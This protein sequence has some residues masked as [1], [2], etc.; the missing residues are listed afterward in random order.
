MQ[1]R[2]LLKNARII[3]EGLSYKGGIF[4]CG[5]TIADIFDYSVENDRLREK[6]LQGVEVVDLQGCCLM[7]GVIDTHVHFR[8][9][10]ATHKGCIASESEAARLGGV[11]SYLDMPNNNPPAIDAAALSAKKEI[12]ARDSRINYGFYLGATDTNL[13]QIKRAREM[14]ACAV[15]VFFGSSTGNLLMSDGGAI[16]TLFRSSPLMIAA[17]CEDNGIIAANLERF[18]LLYGE[19]IPISAHPEIRSR[20]ACLSST[21]R[22]VELALKTGAR[23]HIMHVSTAEEV[24]YLSEV[25]RRSDRISAET[26]VQYLWFCDEDYEKYGARI[27]CNPAI[28]S[29]SDRSALWDAVRGGVLSTI[30]TDHAPHLPADKSGG[31]LQ[32]ASGIPL[33]QY[34]LLMMIEKASRGDIS[35][36]MVAEKMC[37]APARLFSIEHRG[38]IR[39]G[40]YA[41]LVAFRTG[42]PSDIPPASRCGWSPLTSFSSTIVRTFVNGASSACRGKSLYPSLRS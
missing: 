11:T 5:E 18:K 29:A 35:L 27:K 37:H 1:S 34:S 15:K 2:L 20:Q 12:A 26:C 41:D 23:L 22:A 17:H 7:S 4:V 8:E 31:Y 13:S 14:G 3:N 32:A 38:F 36:P 10:G 24:E 28:K 30:S 9:P 6:A 25:M 42:C 33:V 21:R 40:Y 39:K 19:N 16:E